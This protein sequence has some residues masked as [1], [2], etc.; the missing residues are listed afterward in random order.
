MA[1]KAGHAYTLSFWAADL[2]P[3]EFDPVCP[4]YGSPGHALQVQLY[5]QA[6]G[7]LLSQAVSVAPCGASC[8]S[9]HEFQCLAPSNDTATLKFYFGGQ[10]TKLKVSGVTLDEAPPAGGGP[11]SGASDGVSVNRLAISRPG[12]SSQRADLEL[13]VDGVTRAPFAVSNDVY[14]GLARNSLRFCYYQRCGQRSANHRQKSS[15]AARVESAPSDHAKGVSRSPSG[16]HSHACAGAA[17]QRESARAPLA[18]A[19]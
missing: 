9:T 1:L 11:G 4:L 13:V 8:G 3:N 19:V 5:G 6:P 2:G 14:A 18:R 7:E 17:P 12:R 16:W 10:W 15:A